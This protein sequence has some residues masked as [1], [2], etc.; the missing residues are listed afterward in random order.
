[1]S[2]QLSIKPLL[3][4]LIVL[5][6]VIC[7]P[8]IRQSQAETFSNFSATP[9]SFAVFMARYNVLSKVVTGG[10]AGTAF[11]ISPSKAIT[12]FHVL[13]QKSFATTSKLER[14]KLWLVREGRAA[15]EL[16]S[17]MLR[18][19]KQ[20][21]LTTI[22]FGGQPVAKSDEVYELESTSTANTVSSTDVLQTD[23]FKA[24]TPGP[25]LAFVGDE[26]VI[27]RVSQLRRIHT[28]G[29]L[30][31]AARIDLSSNDVNL[32]GAD[33]LQISYQPIVGLSGGPITR[34]GKVV[35]M[36]SFADPSKQTTWAIHLAESKVRNWF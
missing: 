28:Y 8:K 35:G 22:D 6:L 5:L 20:R 25:E 12:A 33:C 26:L 31:Q 18:E 29:A 36:N 3:M 27:T 16:D 34:N 19:Q 21:D 32:V 7:L 30:L 17:Q 14:V 23:G 15:I 2:K 24:N 1:M 13:N 4:P 10:V 11:F 9:K